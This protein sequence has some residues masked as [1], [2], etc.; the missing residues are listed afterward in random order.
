[1]RPRFASAYFN[2]G[3]SY[4]ALGDIPHAIEAFQKTIELDPRN[5]AALQSLILAYN[6]RGSVPD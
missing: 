5:V 1:M 3:N 2:M 6:R 4:V